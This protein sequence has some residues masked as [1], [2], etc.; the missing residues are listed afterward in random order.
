MK[1]R[2]RGQ[3]REEKGKEFVVYEGGSKGEGRTRED[4]LVEKNKEE[5]ERIKRMEEGTETRK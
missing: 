5:V 2:G 4:T 3:K 1:K